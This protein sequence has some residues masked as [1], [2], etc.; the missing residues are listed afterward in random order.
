MAPEAKPLPVESVHPGKRAR[1]T[2]EA[3]ALLGVIFIFAAGPSIGGT[4]GLTSK[5]TTLGD[6]AAHSGAWI[7]P[8]RDL[9]SPSPRARLS[10]RVS[11]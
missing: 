11:Q 6:T 3:T 8:R 10:H 1:T 4:L 9:G 7:R 5:P 2:E